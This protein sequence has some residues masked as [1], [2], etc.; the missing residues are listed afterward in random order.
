MAIQCRQSAL[1]IPYYSGISLV[2]SGLNQHPLLSSKMDK[3]LACSGLINASTD[4]QIEIGL[5]HEKE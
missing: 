1:S 5:H 3:I 2:G 4:K